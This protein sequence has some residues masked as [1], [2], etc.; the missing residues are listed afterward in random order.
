MIEYTR[1]VVAVQE[2]MTLNQAELVEL[3]ERMGA[4]AMRTSEVEARLSAAVTDM[5]LLEG[6]ART[7]IDALSR[8]IHRNM[9]LRDVITAAGLH[10]SSNPTIA[11][12]AETIYAAIN[13]T[14]DVMEVFHDM[15][16]GIHEASDA[17]DTFI[18][19]AANVRRSAEG[20]LVSIHDLME[21]T[22]H[23][24]ATVTEYRADSG[25][26]EKEQ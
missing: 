20:E 5:L 11:A 16:G 15:E 22:A 18:K 4:L 19:G 25:L 9:D 3:P 14:R 10:N 23:I 6:E 13:K 8:T 26:G 21:S 12:L 2:A 17:Q 24:H 7:I 1:Q